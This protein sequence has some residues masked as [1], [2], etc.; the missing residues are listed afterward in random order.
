[1]VKEKNAQH[2]TLNVQHPMEDWGILYEGTFLDIR[3]IC[4]KKNSEMNTV[5]MGMFLFSAV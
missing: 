5:A 2:R 4:C 1:M 3:H